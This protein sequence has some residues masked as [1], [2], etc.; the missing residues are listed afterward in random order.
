[1][2]IFLFRTLADKKRKGTNE[3]WIDK[4]QIMTA[5]MHLDKMAEPLNCNSANSARGFDQR[6]K[7]WSANLFH[8]NI[9]V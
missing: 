4:S 2:R 3:Q 8:I 7:D 5:L 6:R 9:Q 1:M